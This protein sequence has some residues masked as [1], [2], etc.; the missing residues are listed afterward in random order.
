MFMDNLV[1]QLLNL[2]REMLACQEQLLRIA[3]IRQDAMRAYDVERLTALIEEERAYMQR[4]EEFTRRRLALIGQFRLHLKNAQPNVTEIAKH[5]TEPARTQ[6]L[7]I[8]TQLRNVTEK[9][10]RNTRINATVSEAV[11]KSIAKV[12]KI[13]TG[14][15]QHAGLYMRNGRKASVRGIHL[16]EVT[17]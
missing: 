14:I 16:L 5:T 9:L 11:V 7:A 13:V 15:A 1:A 6:L 10:E 12:L 2:L 4:S 3:L 8:A 17:A